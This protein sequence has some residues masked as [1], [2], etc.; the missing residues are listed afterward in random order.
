M[1]IAAVRRLSG[2]PGLVK[3]YFLDMSKI[4]VEIGGI[5]CSIE[6]REYKLIHELKHKI[7][8]FTPLLAKLEDAR[9]IIEKT[10]DTEKPYRILIKN[11][12]GFEKRLDCLDIK[13]DFWIIL[14]YLFAPV[15]LRKNGIVLHGAGIGN[16]SQCIS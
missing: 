2:V 14:L 11:R 12:F 16:K 10:T 9:A 6:S 13:E 3:L 15:L 4:K 7:C 8:G 5:L 1:L